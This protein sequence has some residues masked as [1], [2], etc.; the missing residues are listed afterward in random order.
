MFLHNFPVFCVK[1]FHILT[2]TTTEKHIC[3]EHICV[4]SPGRS[5]QLLQC[6]LSC[7]SLIQ[8]L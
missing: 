7:S 1:K 6:D 4:C 3:F 8:L 2:P 5:G